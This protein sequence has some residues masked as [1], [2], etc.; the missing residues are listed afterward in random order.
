MFLLSGFLL[1]LV[2]LELYCYVLGD[3]PS[4]IFC[5]K[6]PNTSNI[7]N[8][9]KVIK[10]EKSP[11]FQDVVSDELIIWSAIVPVGPNFTEEIAKALV[12]KDSLPPLALLSNLPP[13]VPGHVHIVVK[14][15]PGPCASLWHLIL[16]NICSMLNFCFLFLSSETPSIRTFRRH[17]FEPTQ[18]YKTCDKCTISCCKDIGLH[19]YSKCLSREGI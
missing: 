13:S 2:A 15:P 16:F 17:P 4:Q 10:A 7:A 5:V 19:G 11:K 14:A 8:L 18:T 1:I 6:L 9:R 12:D 3:N